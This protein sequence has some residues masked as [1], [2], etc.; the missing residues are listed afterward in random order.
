MVQIFSF[1]EALEI[2]FAFQRFDGFCVID[3]HFMAVERHKIESFFQFQFAGLV[4]D[5][6]SRAEE[7]IDEIP[8]G[9]AMHSD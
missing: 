3:F 2:Y 7:Q 5:G 4:H 1:I 8:D 9:P 6:V